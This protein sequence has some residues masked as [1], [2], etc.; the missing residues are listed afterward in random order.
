[1]VFQVLIINHQTNSE[2][3]RRKVNNY[4]SPA[5]AMQAPRGREVSPTQ[6]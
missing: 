6:S 1:M 5:T 3:Y 4:S 2:K